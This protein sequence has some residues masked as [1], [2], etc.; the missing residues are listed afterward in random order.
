[1]LLVLLFIVSEI[2]NC[3]YYYYYYYYVRFYT[4]TQFGHVAILID[5]LSAALR[6]NHTAC[7][8]QK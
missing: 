5:H 8:K 3:Y 4:K 1:M 6:Q 2:L 7:R